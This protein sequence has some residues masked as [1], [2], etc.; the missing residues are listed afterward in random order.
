[1]TKLFNTITNLIYT[2]GFLSLI[3]FTIYAIIN[4]NYEKRN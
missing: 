1:M 3:S 2:G 4:K